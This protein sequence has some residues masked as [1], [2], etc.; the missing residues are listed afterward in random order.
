MKMVGVNKRKIDN[1]KNIKVNKS[2][3]CWIDKD[4]QIN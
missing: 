3:D 1:M 4:T 2:S